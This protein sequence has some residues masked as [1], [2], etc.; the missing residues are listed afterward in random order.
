MCLIFREAKDRERRMAEEWRA[1][2]EAAEQERAKAAAAEEKR[3]KVGDQ[4][5]AL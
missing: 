5:R 2:A 4:L 1:K 3:A